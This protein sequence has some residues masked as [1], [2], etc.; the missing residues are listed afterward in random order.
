MKKW[1]A[2]ALC[3]SAATLLAGIPK[4]GAQ[5]EV[6]AAQQAFADAVLKRDKAALERLLADDLIYVHSNSRLETKGEILEVISSGSTL[7]ESIEFQEVTAR[8]FDGIVVTTQ[9]ATIRTKQTGVA[10]LFVTMVWVRQ[11]GRWQLASRQA[12]RLP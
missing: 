10:N 4:P 7:Y 9:K 8:Q 12:S 5:K 1:L 11:K 2:V 3:L 6:L